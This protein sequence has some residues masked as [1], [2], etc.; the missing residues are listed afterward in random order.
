LW[1]KPGTPFDQSHPLYAA[2]QAI[3]AVRERQP[4]LRYGRQY[5]RPV[6]GDGINFGVSPFAPGVVAFSRILNDEEVVVA[7][8]TATGSG[9]QIFVIVDDALNHAG[10]ALDVLY[11]NKSSPTAP[12]A[13]TTLG[14]G[15]TLT[16]HEVDGSIS[17]GPLTAFRV[18]LQPLEVQILG[19]Q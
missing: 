4:A 15:G 14:G 10:D 19:R 12:G 11:S 18:T 7:A 8:N 2:I 17:N 5:M 3:A 6:S 16:V 1:G 13:V 9:A